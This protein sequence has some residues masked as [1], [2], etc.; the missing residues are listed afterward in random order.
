MLI[1]SIE[2]DPQALVA[3][4]LNSSRPQKKFSP[5]TAQ[6]RNGRNTLNSFHMASIALISKSDK[7]LTVKENDRL[8]PRMN[9]ATKILNTCKLNSAI[10][11]SLPRD[12]VSFIQG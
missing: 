10:H 7:D 6:K 4:Q 12:Q 9:I 2:F 1:T 3:S 11:Q 5:I 8:I